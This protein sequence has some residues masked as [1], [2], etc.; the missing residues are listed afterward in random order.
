LRPFLPLSRGPA[1][2]RSCSDACRKRGERAQAVAEALEPLG[3]P[4]GGDEESVRALVDERE[5]ER[6]S[7][8]ASLC[9]L[10]VAQARMVDAGNTHASVALRN[11]PELLDEVLDLRSPKDLEWFTLLD[12]VLVVG[13]E[14]INPKSRVGR[15]L[16]ESGR[17]DLLTRHPPPPFP[18]GWSGTAVNGDPATSLPSARKRFATSWRCSAPVIDDPPLTAASGCFDSARPVALSSF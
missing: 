12:I 11:T 3:G 15:A 14:G 6:G 18:P 7:Y 4:S 1:P 9:E 2:R 13:R 5:V 17:Q 8:E 10:A 16:L